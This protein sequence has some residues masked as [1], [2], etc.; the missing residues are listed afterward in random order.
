[1]SDTIDLSVSPYFDDYDRDKE[2]YKI[3]YKPSVPV[4]ARELNQVQ[5]IFQNQIEN[6]SGVNY[7][8][9]DIVSGIN[10]GYNNTLDAVIL[11]P[12]VNGVYTDNILE[13]L[14]DAELTGSIT[15]VRALVVDYVK[16][17]I[18][19]KQQPTV[20][21]KYV[22]TGVNTD[23]V[24]FNKFTD[25]E[26]LI[27]ADKIAAIT[28]NENSTKYV[29]SSVIINDGVIYYKGYFLNVNSQKLI[30]NQYNTNSDL[31]V[32]ISI[33]ESV[34]T[35][36]T[37]SSLQDNSYN[38]SNYSAIGADRLKIACTLSKLGLSTSIPS[39]FV[40]LLQLKLGVIQY[41]LDASISHQIVDAIAHRT[42][43][44]SG[45]FTV[46]EFKVTPVNTL[47]TLFNNGV[48]SVG[49]ICDTG[50]VVLNRPPLPSELNTINGSDF[51]SINLSK[52]TAIVK[53][54]EYV[55][56][57]SR[58]A[59]VKKTNPTNTNKFQSL[60][61][62]SGT[63]FNITSITGKLDL[64]TDF[65]VVQLYNKPQTSTTKKLIGSAYA[66]SIITNGNTRLY[67]TDINTF[68]EVTFNTAT[69]PNLSV[70][71]Y[72]YSKNFSGYVQEYTNTKLVIEHTTGS[73]SIGDVLE[74]SRNGI[75]V[76]CLTI[77]DI[78]FDSVKSL[79]YGNAFSANLILNDYL[80][81]GNNYLMQAE[82]PSTTRII[83]NNIDFTKEVV[84]GN[85]VKYSN[86]TAEITQVNKNYI[87]VNYPWTS[88]STNLLYKSIA[89]IQYNNKNLYTEFPE[90]YITATNNKTISVVNQYV[91]GFNN[92][93]EVD[94]PYQIGAELPF[95]QVLVQTTAGVFTAAFITATRIRL[96]NTTIPITDPTALITVY[97]N[98]S[99]PTNNTKTS[100]KN[101]VALINKSQANILHDKYG[102]RFQDREISLGFTDV[103]NIACVRYSDNANTA[104]NY[105]NSCFDTILVTSAVGIAVGD[106]LY[107]STSKA[108]VIIISG[109]VIYL[110]YLTTNHLKNGE[111]CKNW[112]KQI[113]I[114]IVTATSGQYIDVTKNYKLISG[115]NN[116]V[117][118]IS[119]LSI[120]N[121]KNIPTNNLVIVFDR[122]TNINDSDFTTIDSYNTEYSLEKNKNI[123]DYRIFSTAANTTGVGTIINPYIINTANLNPAERT[124]VFKKFIAPDSLFLY[125]YDYY[126]GRIDSAIIDQFGKYKVISGVPDETPT[127]PVITN[128]DLLIAKLAIPP[129]VS[130]P[131]D[132]TVYPEKTIRYTMSD[133]SKL[134]DRVSNIESFV[135]LSILEQQA[136]NTTLVDKT[137][138]VRPKTGFATDNFE[139]FTL[140]D[141]TNSSYS[142]SI[143]VNNKSLKPKTINSNIDLVL[144]GISNNYRKTG[145]L[146][147]LPYTQNAN[148]SQ[149][150]ANIYINANPFNIVNWEG[151]LTTTPKS[152]NWIT[153]VSKDNKDSND[154][155]N[156]INW[157]DWNI[158]STNYTNKL[159]TNTNL[160]EKQLSNTYTNYT[161]Q[162]FI[163]LDATAL[164]PNTEL[165][166]YINNIDMTGYTIPS[167]CKLVKGGTESTNNISFIVGEELI[168]YNPK[169]RT[170]VGTKY[171]P[172][173]KSNVIVARVKDLNSYSGNNSPYHINKVLPRV[174]AGNTEFIYIEWLNYTGDFDHL[175]FV[176]EPYILGKTSGAIGKISTTKLVANEYG[177][178]DGVLMIP[179]PAIST[180][181]KFANK[182]N[183][184]KLLSASTFAES[185]FQSYDTTN[186]ITKDITSINNKT[187]NDSNVNTVQ[188]STNNISNNTNWYSPLSQTFTVR[189]KGG[190]HATSLDL[191]FNTI[192]TK[193]PIIVQIRTIENGNP[194]EIIIPFSEVV[195][196]PKDIVLSNDSTKAT[197]IKFESLVYLTENS[198]YAI[199]LL[200]NSNK[201][202][203]FSASVGGIDIATQTRINE[204]PYSGVLFEPQNISGWKSNKLAN[205]K[206]TLNTAKFDIRNTTNIVLNNIEN[207]NS[208][209]ND[210]L[211]LSTN[212]NSI[213][214]R[215]YNHG[216][217]TTDNSIT[218]SNVI[219]EN[220]PSVLRAS[221]PDSQ[222]INNPI[223]VLVEDAT[224][225]HQ[226][227]NNQAV[228]TTNPGYIKI[229]DEIISYTAVNTTTKL[230]T[231]PIGGR[232]KNSTAIR[233]HNIGDVVSPYVLCGIPLIEINKTFITVTPIDTNNISV[234]TISASSRNYIGGGSNI[235]MNRNIQ[236]ELLTGNMSIMKYGDNKIS[237]SIQ[238]TTG[239]SVNSTT[240]I[241]YITQTNSFDP[242]TAIKYN[243][244]MI[245]ASSKNEFLHNTN[246]KS[247]VYTL[248]LSSTN[249]NTSPILDLSKCSLIATTN[250]IDNAVTDDTQNSTN[251]GFVYV[252]KPVKL[253][254]PSTSVNVLF[255]AFRLA[256][257]SISVYIKIARIDSIL[258]F[259]K[260]DF[261]LVPPKTYPVS[262]TNQQYNEF[263]YELT[264]LPQFSQYQIKIVSKSPSQASY[265]IIKKL[266]LLSTI[267]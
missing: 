104:P 108:K 239:T 259:D 99:F 18:S 91:V 193:L 43:E 240:E 21:V 107:T 39:N 26:N 79:S 205:L 24:I 227:I 90:K 68:T 32:G 210:A 82:A 121:N 27:V 110:L 42:Y 264:N 54:Y 232:G 164:K 145:D 66:L 137:G 6:L 81:N 257:H 191:F 185:N 189:D 71:D 37:D 198:Q 59:S 159:T 216:L 223:T 246:K 1:M 229:D 103:F 126:V 212:S 217:H 153:Q 136:N 7:N 131:S 176:E 46:D 76:I 261:I 8:D 135:A 52:G 186:I 160:L 226:I 190:C 138:I 114:N 20:Y 9:G 115:D 92:T 70:G 112:N 154:T 156:S 168:W 256:S 36:S 151:V 209:V 53:G 119:K 224:V 133:I 192:D 33:N 30:I 149:T 34:V 67:V 5:S 128:G 113:D 11:Q 241:S 56:D 263:V 10:V 64:S 95:G 73:L 84:V 65:K 199:V 203:L 116:Q 80:I 172:V 75:S 93:L 195:V 196:Y 139:T 166:L 177:I 155:F 60:E 231:I 252:S 106:I 161:Q 69:T 215:L 267:N 175:D 235:Q 123:L 140:A 129:F 206:Y 218:I 194:T 3:L 17:T 22:H 4:Q 96:S 85:Y 117:Y 44:T 255:D 248:S 201:Y 88:Q 251:P 122:Y 50:A 225:F 236:Y 132:I 183:Y 170:Q 45:N 111:I 250:K 47:D 260:Q 19:E 51:V 228:G 208:I 181:P 134:S 253:L 28:I 147:T 31:R 100:S 157:G 244:P 221:L 200:T 142:A 2:Y 38:Y 55:F 125:D 171:Q 179:N 188:I 98:K 83:S 202:K 169:K 124:L 143:D 97:T 265:P 222:V 237:G 249:P 211:T 150:K 77:N 29:G 152:D 165:S 86:I 35:T 12:L 109:T 207:T 87:V 230:I 146:I 78:R 234:I 89:T 258:E 127:S 130:S 63:Y 72:V 144:D 74:N 120:I 57:K 197:N 40:E 238:T 61:L 233:T 49:D 13:S 167:L 182:N 62:N 219:S 48:Y 141:I 14:V 262:S 180:N 245:V 242:L 243:T 118:D 162:Q 148:L 102:T 158:L 184:I 15:N 94:V 174:Y 213:Q 25:N 178:W 16:S 247:I 214:I 58:I 163:L 105:I 101:N 173:I 23:G 204:L 187:L 266:R 41:K 220:A 254:Q